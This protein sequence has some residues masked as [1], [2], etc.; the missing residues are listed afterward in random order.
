MAYQDNNQFKLAIIGYGQMGREIERVAKSQGIN[1]TEIFEIDNP[2]SSDKD[3]AF[4]IAIDFSYPENVLAN[5]ENVA[6]LGKNLVV[7]TTG[8][9]DKIDYVKRI[10][11]SYEIGFLY[12]SN[13]SI[14]VN[15][16]FRIIEYASSLID[17]FDDFDI[18]GNEIHHVRKK[19]SPSGTAR[20]LAEIIFKNVSR[21]TELVSSRIDGL[22]S[23]HQLH[24]SSIRGGDV[25]GEH[26]IW[27]DSVSD[28]IQL[29]HRAKNRI[30][31][32][33][34]AVEAAKWI[35]GKKGFYS[36]DDM[37]MSLW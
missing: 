33:K 21:K 4:D 27:L 7:G 6:K 23:P 22:I 29:T 12:S 35:Y 15:L 2:V 10:V 30:G 13:F 11:E 16:F 3:Y 31:F 19:D 1:V 32:A 9:Y 24:F 25:F 18:Y 37:L 17:K 36:F 34:G 5:I 20:K 14:G 8:W 28:N 26:T